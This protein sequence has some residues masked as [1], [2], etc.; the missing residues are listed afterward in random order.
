ME[1]F[2]EFTFDSAHYLP[3]VPAEHKCRQM[4][5]HTYRLRVV[6]S[7]EPDRATGWLIDFAVLKQ[8]VSETLNIVDHKT[9]NNIPGLDNPTCELLAI[10]LWNKI[11]LGLP[12]LTKIELYETPT[13]GVVYTGPLDKK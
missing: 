7:G 3:N 10:W 8:K 13:S 2:K 9:L 1:I 4:H 6:L 12:L 11:A 5:G